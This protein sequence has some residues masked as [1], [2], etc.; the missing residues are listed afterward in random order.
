M[1]RSMLRRFAGPAVICASAYVLVGCDQIAAQRR[2]ASFEVD[3]VPAFYDG[4]LT[5]QYDG[6]YGPQ[7]IYSERGWRRIEQKAPSSSRSLHDP[8]RHKVYTWM[9]WAPMR[10]PRVYPMTREERTS[11]WRWRGVTKAQW[12]SGCKAA[13]EQGSLYLIVRG[14]DLEAL[15]TRHYM[16]CLTS[17]G[18]LLS[19]GLQWPE[20]YRPDYKA[21]T[22]ARGPLPAETF[23]PGS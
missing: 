12:R 15:R 23:K 9:D 13:G 11:I 5:V 4:P 8:V 1:F 18:V 16:A 20:G 21:I 2:E 7:V 10:R 14:P 3:P 17:D 19:E 6:I 22:V